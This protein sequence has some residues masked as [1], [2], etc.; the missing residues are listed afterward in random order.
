MHNLAQE[1]ITAFRLKDPD[2]LVHFSCNC[3]V[4]C[5]N[6]L[7]REVVK[8]LSLEVKSIGVELGDIG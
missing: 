6:R 7:L 1:I 2:L 5:W 4:I 3:L 8:S